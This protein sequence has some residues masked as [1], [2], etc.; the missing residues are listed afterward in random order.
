MASRSF[1]RR[2]SSCL[3]SD[4]LAFDIGNVKLR[5]PVTLLFSIKALTIEAS[6]CDNR[7]RS[8]SECGYLKRRL[9]YVTSWRQARVLQCAGS[10]PQWRIHALFS[11]I[12]TELRA[13]GLLQFRCRS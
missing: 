4:S 1:V 6:T 7:L 13:S 11:Q 2:S 8:F 12:D 3:N 10:H 5:P 9:T